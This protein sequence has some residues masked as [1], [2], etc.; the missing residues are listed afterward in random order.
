MPR[1]ASQDFGFA[2]GDCFGEVFA[3]DEFFERLPG[4]PLAE[5]DVAAFGL[6]VFVH[7]AFDMP[8]QGFQQIEYAEESFFEFFFFAGDDFVVHADGCHS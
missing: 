3:V 5:D 2:P 7:V 1:A 4:F 6:D 8:G